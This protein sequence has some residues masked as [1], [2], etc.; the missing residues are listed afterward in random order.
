MIY[1]NLGYAVLTGA[2]I[3]IEWKVFTP[4]LQYLILFYG[5]AVSTYAIADIYDD[6]ICRTSNRSDAWACYEICPCCLPK[7]VGLQWCLLAL[8]M[9]VFGIWMALALM[10]DECEDESWWR[11]AA[12]NFIFSVDIQWDEFW[13]F[14]D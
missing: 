4:V 12:D 8:A 7:C 3:A 1:L 11:C 9:Q 5:V 13:P 2:F 10:S 14:W 6:L